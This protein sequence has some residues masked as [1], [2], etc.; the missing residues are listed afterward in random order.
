MNEQSIIYHSLEAFDGKEGPNGF[1]AQ[2][3][4]RPS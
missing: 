2:I 3:A 4:A 1:R